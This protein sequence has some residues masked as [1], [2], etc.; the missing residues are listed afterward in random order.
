MNK[1]SKNENLLK[2]V[3]FN[4][5][6]GFDNPEKFTRQEVLLWMTGLYSKSVNVEYLI[7]ESLSYTGGYKYVD[8]AGRDFDCCDNSDS[9]TGTVNVNT[10][11]VEISGLANKTGSL[12]ITVCNPL[13]DAEPISYFYVPKD[14]VPLVWMDCYGKNSNDKRIRFTWQDV[15]PKKYADS[16]RSGYFC[17]FERFRLDSFKQLAQMS[18]MEFY[19]LNPHLLLNSPAQV[20]DS[21]DDSKSYPTQE[22][23]SLCTPE[24]D[25]FENLNYQGQLP[26]FLYEKS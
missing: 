2:N 24:S 7:E 18:D 5:L 4:T 23:S 12:R 16:N 9:K 22:T 19:R 8:E 26:T 15:R 21:F 14:Y 11:T 13:S 25:Q 17:S 10:R 3:I 1:T 20:D 6:P